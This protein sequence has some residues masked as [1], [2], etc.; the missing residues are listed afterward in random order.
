MRFQDKLHRRHL[1]SL[2][3]IMLQDMCS[4]RAVV[5]GEHEEDGICRAFLTVRQQIAQLIAEG[6]GS[7]HIGLV[8]MAGHAVPFRL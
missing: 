7:E 4:H 1:V 6:E 3:P 5:L 8:D 2:P